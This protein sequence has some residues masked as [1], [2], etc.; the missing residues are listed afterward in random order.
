MMYGDVDEVWSSGYSLTNYA[1]PGEA[2]LTA[3]AL[4]Q[5]SAQNQDQGMF[6][7][8]PVYEDSVYSGETLNTFTISHLGSEYYDQEEESEIESEV[9]QISIE[10]PGQHVRAASGMLRE[11][12]PAPEVGQTPQPEPESKPKILANKKNRVK[13]QIERM[14]A[15]ECNCDQLLAQL[16]NCPECWNMIKKQI[17]GNTGNFLDRLL[18]SQTRDILLVVLVGVFIILVLNLLT[19]FAGNRGNK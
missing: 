6:A 17:L 11:P 5:N 15:T 7:A 13:K 1:R 18:T 3:N 10:E 16:E 12:V 8:D 2:Q 9:S 14:E 4:N 19:S